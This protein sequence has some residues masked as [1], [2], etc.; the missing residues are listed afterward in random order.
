MLFHSTRWSCGGRAFT[1]ASMNAFNRLNAAAR[2][3]P[4]SEIVRVYKGES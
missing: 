1:D 3:F 2:L 4:I